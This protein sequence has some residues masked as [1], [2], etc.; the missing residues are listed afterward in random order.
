MSEPLAINIKGLTKQYHNGVNALCGVNL[1]IKQGDFFGL[2]GLNGAG[3]TTLISIL[4]GLVHHTKGKIEICG[5]DMASSPSLAKNCIGLM[6]QEVNMNAFLTIKEVMFN[7]GGYY[8]MS[9]E[10]IQKC[11]QSVLAEVGLKSLDHRR[12]QSLS[13]GMKR[14][15][16]LARSLL[17]QPKI[18]VLDEP[19]AGV[20]VE[21][22]QDIW[23]LLRKI[24][25]AGTTVLLTTHYMEEAEYLCD[26]LAILHHGVIIDQGDKSK[27]ELTA[28]D[29]HLVLHVQDEIAQL[30][31]LEG[32][33][34]TRI[35]TRS[36]SLKLGSDVSLAAYLSA[37]EAMGTKLQHV[38]SPTSRLEQYFRSQTGERS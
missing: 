22:R 6:P 23:E 15:L 38:S 30:P 4:V 20:D 11:Y 32:A 25:Q 14:R 31:E 18:L 24:N 13:G 36:F 16:L 21:L 27:L 33:E 26:R 7:H 28:H 12:V 10:K 1:E 29:R 35:D 2:L 17:V 3:K 8:G 5:H 19:T 34:A 9:R 37:L